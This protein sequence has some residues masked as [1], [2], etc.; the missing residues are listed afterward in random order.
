M[1]MFDNSLI[2]LTS[3]FYYRHVVYFVVQFMQWKVFF[4]LFKSKTGIYLDKYHL[5]LT[6]T[7]S[8]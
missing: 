5:L 6:G 4:F 3:L 2:V 7:R 8:C 1:I